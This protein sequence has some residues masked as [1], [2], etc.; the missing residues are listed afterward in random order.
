MLQPWT[1]ENI[2]DQTGKLAIITGANSGIG[3]ETAFVL[4]G[5]GAALIL[6]A[7]N[8]EKGKNAAAKIRNR[9][10]DANIR[11][12]QLDLSNITSIQLFATQVL[13][14]EQQ[15]HILINNAGVMAP[16]YRKTKDGFELQF[17]TNHL[18]HFAFTGLLLP[19][20]V[21]TPLAR[22]ITVSS[23]AH[24][25]GRINF[26]NL[27]GSKGYRRWKFYGQSK[28]ANLL[29]A[30]ELERRFKMNHVEAMSLVCHPGFASTNLTA[31]GIGHS[32]PWIGKI[33]GAL[34]GLMSQSAAMGALPTL[35]A[36]TNP[37]LQGGEYIGPTGP[38]E[39]RGYPG[40]VQSSPRSRD[41]E[42]GRRLWDMSEQMTGVTYNDLP[43]N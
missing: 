1:V 11:V 10:K 23:L 19:I 4:A 41:E 31:A 17:G 28:L 38:R 43:R 27:D 39:M 29:F 33:A 42:A 12:M 36:A 7:R 37:D 25:T 14:Q 32:T 26:D 16:P 22:V 34:G 35:F 40:I 5:S 9:Y 3:Y 15:L 13:E 20:I 6:A 2:A 8:L 24:R 30:Y 18:G 21:K